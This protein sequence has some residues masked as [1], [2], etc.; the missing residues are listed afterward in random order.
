M[1]DENKT[2][3]KIGEI[4]NGSSNFYINKSKQLN[5][6]VEHIFNLIRDAYVLYINNSV[7]SAAFFSIA[8]IE[9]VGK[10]HMGMYVSHTDEFVKKD[11]LRDHKTKQIVGANYTVSMSERITQAI[12]KDELQ[13]IYSIIY[14]G[15]LKNIRE[16]SIYCDRK[17]EKIVVPNE[18]INKKFSRNLLL[19]T[20]ELFDDNL[21]GYTEYTFD[22]ANQ[23]DTIF[24]IVANS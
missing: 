19:F 9:E 21:L 13:K 22:I 4:L 20:I 17:D 10:V 3:E 24:E 2:M 7:A 1:I 15:G 5:K 8:A 14:S 18:I 23:V 11:K 12:G 6:C 16:A